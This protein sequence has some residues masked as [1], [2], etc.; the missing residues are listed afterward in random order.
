MTHLRSAGCHVRLGVRHPTRVEEI[1]ADYLDDREPQSWLPKLAHIDVVINAVGI[2]RETPSAP[3]AAVHTEAPIALLRACEIVGVRRFIQISALGIDDTTTSE[4]LAY[5]ASKL[6]ADRALMAS[7]LEICVLRPSLVFGLDGASSRSLLAAASLPLHLLP[8][9]GKQP[10]QPIHIDD[11]CALITLL[12]VRTEAPPRLLPA[13]GPRALGFAELLAV[14]RCNLGLPP[15]WQIALPM[16]W[17]R[18]LVRLAEFLPQRVVARETLAMLERGNTADPEPTS[19]I[20]GH[21][22][23]PPE[24][25]VAPAEREGTR[26]N[27]NALWLE[28]L[29]RLALALL[30]LISG[31]L[32][33]IFIDPRVP[34]WLARL[35]LDPTA[36]DVARYAA[37]GLDLAFAGL[38]LFWPRRALWLAQF[39]LVAAYTPLASLA[40]PE[41]W[42]HPFGPLLKNLPIAVLLLWLWANTPVKK[43]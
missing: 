5:F 32:G 10:V 25:F 34:A 43:S 20:L 28:P 13:V 7:P 4:P 11:L 1:A 27:A 31:L 40:A 41:E 29:A 2:L 14:Y 38:S 26:R 37:S 3:F 22:P 6:A 21:A 23:R 39:L 16:S 18:G 17:V 24:A 8:G 36:A 15:P 19:R 33:L 9:E 35:G 30:W 12:V 42:L